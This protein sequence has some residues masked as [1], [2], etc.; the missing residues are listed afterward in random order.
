[1]TQNT[2]SIDMDAHTAVNVMVLCFGA[3]VLCG[4]VFCGLVLWMANDLI[5]L[6]EKNAKGG[7][8]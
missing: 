6:A 8:R 4:V 1:M 5:K 3:F 7:G 2:R